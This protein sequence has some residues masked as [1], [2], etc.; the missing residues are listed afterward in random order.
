M[1]RCSISLVIKEEHINTLRYHLTS[2]RMATVKRNQKTVIIGKGMKKLEVLC[3]V[4]GG[5]KRCS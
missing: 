4:G 3:T 1:K 5:I 2:H